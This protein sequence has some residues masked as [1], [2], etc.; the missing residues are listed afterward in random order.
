[1]DN[2]VNEYTWN[3]LKKQLQ[4]FKISN[5]ALYNIINDI[6]YRLSSFIDIYN[7][8]EL[9]NA[10]LVLASEEGT[11]YEPKNDII[12]NMVVTTIRNS[13]LEGVASKFYKEYGSDVYLDDNGIK[14]IT[15]KAVEFFMNKD[16][17]RE[18]KSIKVEDNYY[19]NI[20]NKYPVAYKALVE[21]SKLSKNNRECEYNKV[22]VGKPYEIDEVDNVVNIEEN[23]VAIESGISPLFNNILL[24][25]LKNIKDNKSPLFFTD[26]FKMVSRNFEKTLKVLE[27]VL[28]HDACYITCNYLLTNGYVSRR[29]ELVRA[30]HLSSDTF[31]KIDSLNEI[32]NKYSE[33]FELIKEN[34]R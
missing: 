16:L 17:E 10:I 33:L 29:K 4:R 25:Y 1:M 6:K 11:F 13:L 19:K 8:E 21:L 30:A 18:S 15:M 27:F 22:L 3:I 26:C 14:E 12:A 5:E 9:R 31:L 7:D 2:I 34:Y 24:G 28:S 20:I 23:N 32:S